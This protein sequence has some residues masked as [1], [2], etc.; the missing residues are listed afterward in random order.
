MTSRLKLPKNEFEEQNGSLSF[1]ILCCSADWFCA[2]RKAKEEAQGDRRERHREKATSSLQP[3]PLS[4]RNV[5]GLRHLR[6]CL[7]APPLHGIPRLRSP[8]W[9]D[10]LHLSNAPSHLCISQRRP[11][12]P[13]SSLPMF[14]SPPRPCHAKRTFHYPRV[15]SSLV[16]FFRLP[17]FADPRSAR[18]VSTSALPRRE[19]RS[20]SK[21]KLRRRR[22]ER[23]EEAKH[24]QLKGNR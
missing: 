12:V 8:S 15:R 16:D 22:L 24:M 1:K 11:L 17:S 21:T 2:W 20:G 5:V 6:L 7:S 14:S 9:R 3:L 10:V 23:R 4:L 19:N 18:T 13:S